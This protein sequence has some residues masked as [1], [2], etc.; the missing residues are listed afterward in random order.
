MKS[1]GDFLSKFHKLTPPNDAL[2]RAVAKAVSGVLGTPVAKDRVRVHN[3]I[4]YVDVSSVAKHKLRLER[5]ELLEL[6]YE[7]LPKA[8]DLIR[9]VR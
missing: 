5:K 6:L 2:R 3:H 1:A 8:R 7:S 9:D 4:A